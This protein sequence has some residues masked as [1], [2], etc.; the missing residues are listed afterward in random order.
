LV[1]ESQ[2]WRQRTVCI[3]HADITLLEAGSLLSVAT[4]TQWMSRCP[5]PVGPV[6]HGV[7]TGFLVF[8]ER[9]YPQ[10]DRAV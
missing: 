6:T 3:R 7:D 1:P 2:A 9:T 4:P 8:N 5:R 10:S